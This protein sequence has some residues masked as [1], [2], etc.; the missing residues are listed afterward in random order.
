M[1]NPKDLSP[2]TLAFLG[3]SVFELLV[4]EMLVN[5]ANRPSAEFHTEKIKFVSAAAQ[6]KAFKIIEPDLTDAEL[7][8]FKR[9][10]NAHTTNT[11]KNMSSADY[12]TA[13]GIEALFGF[14]YLSGEKDRLRELF[15]K[16]WTNT[17]KKQ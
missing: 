9:G 3:D 5:E 4:R 14:L 12:H 8:I 7:A 17:N 10:R 15:L 1:N 6:A 13:T 11:P 2:L 16:I